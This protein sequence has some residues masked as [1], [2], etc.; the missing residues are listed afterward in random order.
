MANISLRP[1][2]SGDEAFLSD[3]VIA[4]REVEPGYRELVPQERTRLLKDQCRIQSAGYRKE[5]P[6][7]FF[8]VVEANTKPI[9]R[10]YVDHTPG[11]IRVV[12]LS[13]LPKFQGH[14]IGTQLMK[15]ILAEA[16]RTQIPILLSV[17]V[18]NHGAFR[19]YE[20]LG[21]RQVEQSETHARLRWDS[22]TP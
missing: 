8:L 15:T 18:W 17:V 1:Q 12:E 5:F 14:G 3:L 10:F 16:T 9:G 2:T 19:F 6:N 22:P 21:F 4:T 11:H 7:A 13:L 20:K